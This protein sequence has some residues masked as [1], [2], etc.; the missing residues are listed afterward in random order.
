MAASAREFQVSHAH[1]GLG[2][3]QALGNRLAGQRLECQRRDEARG[4]FGQHHAHLR[5]RV[6]QAAHDLA[7]LVG[8]DAARD[9]QQNMFVFAGLVF[10]GTMLRGTHVGIR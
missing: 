3:P 10:A 8:G 4:V 2:V 5:A 9:P 7:C 6:A 1:F